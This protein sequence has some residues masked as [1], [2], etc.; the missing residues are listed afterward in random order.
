MARMY[1]KARGKSGSTKPKEKKIPSWMRY[2]S[3]EITKLII[4][5]AKAG[6]S[7]S[8]IGVELRDSYGIPDVKTLTQK[9]MTQILKEHAVVKKLPD[10]VTALI[11]KDIKLMKHQIAFKHDIT[12][13]RGIMLTESKINRLAKYYKSRKILPADWKF[14]RTKAKLYLE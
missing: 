9:K 6:K 7:S 3:A 5:L 8:E 13:K 2:K 1:S 10:D 12:V 4:K 14:D 11:K